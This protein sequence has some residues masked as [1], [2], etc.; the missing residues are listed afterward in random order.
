MNKKPVLGLDFVGTIS[1]YPQFFEILSHL[2][3]GTV[4]IISHVDNV[5]V[6]EP[7][8]E[9]FNIRYDKAIAV[10]PNLSKADVIRE[11]EVD[12]YFDDGVS[13]HNDIPASV[14][15]FLVRGI[16]NFDYS[17][18]IWKMDRK[19]RENPGASEG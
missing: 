6:L 9:Q 4:I 1:D 18:K 11:E 5:E 13:N 8:L 7:Y 14:A 15:S 17:K 12:Y 10:P 16:G 19:W 2:W 3:Q